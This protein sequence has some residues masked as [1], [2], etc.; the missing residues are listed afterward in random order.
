MENLKPF[1]GLHCETTATGTL[2]KHIGIELSEPMLFGLGEG[3]SFI[4]WKMK[5]MDFPFL[6]GRIKTDLLTQH[7]CKNL[8]LELNVHETSSKVKA[9]QAVRQLLDEGQPVGLKLDAYYLEYFTKPFHFAGHYVAIYG[10]DDEHAYLVDTRQQGGSV[11][12]SLASLAIARAEKRPMSSK[13][14]YYTIAGNME[15]VDLKEVLIAAMVNNAKQYLAPPINNISYKG[16]LKTSEEVLNWFK[17]SQAIESEFKMAA[18]LMEKAGTGGALFRN[19]YRD[20]IKESYDLLGIEQLAVVHHEFVQI[21]L[22]WTSLSE[23]FSQIAE[24]A[25]F[26]AVQQ[27]SAIFKTLATK[28]KNAMEILASL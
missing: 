11:K 2:L 5:T 19:L 10:Y 28:E 9:W 14:L 21:A 1:D 3:L 4:Y 23:L 6:G 18:S 7:I 17:T 26:D 27:A 25:S 16:I 8:G 13:N 12:T 22:L 20:F 24:T 15:N